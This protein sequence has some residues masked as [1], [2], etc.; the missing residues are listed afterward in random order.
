LFLFFLIKDNVLIKFGG[1]EL[2]YVKKKKQNRENWLDELKRHMN[3][4][5]SIVLHT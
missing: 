3:K 5:S 1:R 2:V 4:K